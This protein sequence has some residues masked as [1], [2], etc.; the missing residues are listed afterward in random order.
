MTISK[1]TTSDDIEYEFVKS[2]TNSPREDH[3][4]TLAQE[5]LTA[6]QEQVQDS[7]L[8]DPSVN[9]VFTKRVPTPLPDFDSDSES[10]DN[11]DAD[12]VSCL[13]VFY[14]NIIASCH[15]INKQ[16]T[17]AIQDESKKES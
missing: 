16:I 11:S 14:N 7:G 1:I 5:T 10:G 2:T 4:S 6:L 15:F 17:S 9:R 13:T 8:N 12:E 3:V